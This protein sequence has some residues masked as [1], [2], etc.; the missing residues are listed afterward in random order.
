MKKYIGIITDEYNNHSIGYNIST[1]IDKM[2]EWKKETDTSSNI[3]KCIIYEVTQYG[4]KLK[5]LGKT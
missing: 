1:D 2:M 4:P 3:I 5:D